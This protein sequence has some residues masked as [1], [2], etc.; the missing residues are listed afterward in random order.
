MVVRHAPRRGR[1]LGING[2]FGGVGLASGP[3]IAAALMDIGSWRSAFLIP[4][5]LSICL[6][7]CFWFAARAAQLH[8]VREDVHPQAEVSGKVMLSAFLTLAVTTMCAGLIFQCIS[9]ALPKLFAIRLNFFAEGSAL[10]VG[11]IVALVFLVA[12]CFQIIGG[13]LADRYPLKWVFV[14]AWCCQ[15]PVILLAASASGIPLV[16]IAILMVLLLNG[17]APA[18]SALF[19]RYSPSRWRA[20]AFGV[21]FVVALGVSALGVPLVARIHDQ[22]GGFYWLFIVLVALAATIALVALA[23]PRERT[24]RAPREALGTAD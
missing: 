14:S 21:K 23:L 15:I 8:K 2:V 4:G 9:I 22:T 18:E 16:G 3:L 12:A 20:T 13:L 17:S 19:A 1:S 24:A 11:G 7:G 5:V 6:G 10:G